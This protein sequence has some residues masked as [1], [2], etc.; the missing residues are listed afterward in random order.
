VEPGRD[1]KKYV[2]PPDL[3]HHTDCH[4]AAV[5]DVININPFIDGATVIRCYGNAKPTD[6]RPGLQSVL[7]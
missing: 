6:Q 7:C 4:G 2:A 3:R 5:V 1:R